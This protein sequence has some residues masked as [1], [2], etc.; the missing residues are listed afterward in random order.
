MRQVNAG[1]PIMAVDRSGRRVEMI[2]PP[3]DDAG[4]EAMFEQ[5]MARG[6]TEITL[7]YPDKKTGELV[8]YATISRP[9]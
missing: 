7:A 8:N 2:D 5:A 3:V 6:I 4:L 1:N 9:S